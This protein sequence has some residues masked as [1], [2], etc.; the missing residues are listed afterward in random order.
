M[1]HDHYAEYRDEAF[2]KRVGVSATKKPLS[3]FWPKRGPQWD[4][5]ATFGDDGVILVEAKAHMAV[6]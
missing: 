1:Q 4:A 2:L 5:L 3:E 6:S